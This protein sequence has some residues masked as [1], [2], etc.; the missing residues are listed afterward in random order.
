MEV[1]HQI[2]V[3]STFIDLKEERK[4]I[5][6]AL[7]ELGCIPVGMEFFPAANEDQWTYIKKVIDQSDYYL[8]IVGGRY[9]ST[10]SEGLSYTEKEYDYAISQ[11]VPVIGFI[12]ENPN[13][14][15]VDKVDLDQEKRIKLEKF[16]DKIKNK[17]LK[18][19]TNPA[20]LG[21]VVSRSLIQI[22]R[23]IPRDGWIRGN[24]AADFEKLSKLQSRISELEQESQS[25][26]L[27]PPPGTELLASDDDIYDLEYTYTYDVQDGFETNFFT[28]EKIP[29]YKT[30]SEMRNVSLSWNQILTHVGPYMFDECSELELKNGLIS[31]LKKV[32]QTNEKKPS[33]NITN[34]NFYIVLTQ[35]VSLSI[36]SKSMKKHASNDS[37]TY[38]SLTPYG[39]LLVQRLKA[40]KKPI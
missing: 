11:N 27:S 31:L 20:D 1:R 24:F 3:S 39:D 38:W 21:G 28:D 6:Q 30:I 13:K 8:V 16:K 33:F 2:F 23:S 29:H 35:F 40:V 25:S 37:H 18:T 7:L 12:H 10:D 9:G 32:I 5:Y 17:L 15:E 14:L 4:E 36:I 26:R 19:W 34:D 22:M